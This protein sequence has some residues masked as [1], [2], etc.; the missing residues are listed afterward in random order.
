MTHERE[1]MNLRR[2]IELLEGNEKIR[3]A[4]IA[5]LEKNK[6]LNEEKAAAMAER[7]EIAAHLHKQADRNVQFVES[8]IYWRDEAK[9]YNLMLTAKAEEMVHQQRHIAEQDLEIE[10]LKEELRELACKSSL[11][12]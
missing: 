2:I 9:F 7:V 5:E 12:V 3:K 8:M 1:L 11:G 4:Q 10:L 6:K